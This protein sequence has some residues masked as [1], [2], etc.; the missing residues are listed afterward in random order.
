M[1]FVDTSFFF[2]L[3]SAYDRDHER[4]RAVFESLRGRRLSDLLLTT[5]HVV[6]E[7]ITLARTRGDHALAVQVGEY[8]YGQKLARIH[9]TTPDEERAAFAYFTNYRDKDYSFIDCLS[10]VVMGAFGINEAW[11][12]D[13]DFAHRFV[14]R[15]E[16]KRR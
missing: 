10:F 1:I 12:V 8:L 13:S 15:P 5:N 16:P 7:T 11:A 3:L 2:P 6:W 4:V 14:V 9:W